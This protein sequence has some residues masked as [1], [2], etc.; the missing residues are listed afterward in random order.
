MEAMW[1]EEA[2]FVLCS[3]AFRT[4]PQAQP[5]THLVRVF[6]GVSFCHSGLRDSHFD[7]ISI[8]VRAVK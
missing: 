8:T 6:M 5:Q 1:A 4:V 3:V 7:E 2:G